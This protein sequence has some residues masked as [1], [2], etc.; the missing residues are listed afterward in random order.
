MKI[1]I[2]I[3]NYNGRK[4]LE[5]FLPSVVQYSILPETEIVV[6]DNGSTDDSINFLQTRYPQIR[7]ILLDKNYG[8]AG[9]Y[10]K[11]LQQVEAE[12]FVLLN[13]D[14]EV[15]ENWLD[16][17]VKEMDARP[18]VAA[19]QPKILAL[20]QRSFFEHAGA[21]GGFIDRLGYPFCRGRLFSSLEKDNHQYDTIIDIFWATGAC[22]FIRSGDFVQSGGFD[23]SFFAHMEEID[24]CWRLKSRGRKII[25]VPQSAVFHLGGGSMSPKNARKTYLNF[26]NNWMMLYKNL[27]DDQIKLLLFPR[28]LLDYIAAVQMLVTGQFKHALQIP[29][30][31]RDFKRLRPQLEAKR[32][33]NLRLT[34]VPL[35]SGVLTKSL[36]RLYYLYGRKRFSQ[37]ANKIR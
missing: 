28:F 13:S 16:P 23:E 11:A 3:L 7:L 37:I 33:E 30:A 24:L 14:V 18:E 9:G 27:P 29:K 25:C 22:L 15:T 21:C 2:V 10:N 19:C 36:L 1:S 17:L 8:F 20:K 26:R 32:Q 34:T 35:P 4:H 5:R 12:Y 6:A 31:R